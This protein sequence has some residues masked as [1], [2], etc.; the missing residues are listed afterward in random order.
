MLHIPC[1]PSERSPHHARLI[2]RGVRVELEED[3]WSVRGY[4]APWHAFGKLVGRNYVMPPLAIDGYPRYYDELVDQRFHFHM[5]EGSIYIPAFQYTIPSSDRYTLPMG[6]HI[7]FQ[8][9]QNAVLLHGWIE[10]TNQQQAFPQSGYLTDAGI[11]A[12][13]LRPMPILIKAMRA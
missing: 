9:R 12:E 2:R 10:I 6:I 8:L 13:S 7:S 4:N 11:G 5:V 1:D 3:P